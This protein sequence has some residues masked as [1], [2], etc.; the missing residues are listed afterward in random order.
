MTAAPVGA[1]GARLAVGIGA[2]AGGPQALQTLLAE[3]PTE[4]PVPVLVVQHIHPNFVGPLVRRLQEACPLPVQVAAA[5]D[6]VRPGRVYVAPGGRHLVVRRG[7]GGRQLVLTLSDAPPRHGVRPAA[8]L[9][10]GSLAE[11]CE[12]GAV[13]VV[14]TGTGK[15]GLDGVRA[16]KAKGGVA[17]AEAQESCVVYGMPR[18]LAEAALA[19]LMV[20]LPEM[21]RALAAVLRERAAALAVH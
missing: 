17:L 16:V 11:A 13:V 15:D 6:V 8:D 20:S 10:F 2:S 7:L 4:V 18:A 21:P 9:L 12:A 5:G 3:F 1:G 14:L 19:D